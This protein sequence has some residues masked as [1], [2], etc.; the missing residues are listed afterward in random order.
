MD[1]L[2]FA[3]APEPA[4]SAQP[5]GEPQAP[6]SEPPAAKRMRV[7]RQAL[8]LLRA[9]D[10]REACALLRDH[11]GTCPAALACL[12]ADPLAHAWAAEALL[13]A[14]AR[15]EAETRALWV[16]VFPPLNPSQRPGNRPH[17]AHQEQTMA[18]TP[19]GGPTRANT[20]T[21]PA[22]KLGTNSRPTMTVNGG[23]G[24]RTGRAKASGTPAMR[25][26]QTTA[27]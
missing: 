4:A 26:K 14:C 1:D 25:G 6:R 5:K 13:A 24:L 2:L 18:N 17:G 20:G 10:P 12:Q 7:A 8:A 11:P 16:A 21:K 27:R 19:S 23:P 3:L 9:G 15:T 22:P